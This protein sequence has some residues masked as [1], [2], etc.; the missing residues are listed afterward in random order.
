MRG[1]ATSDYCHWNKGPLCPD[2]NSY[3]AENE[4]EPLKSL[5]GFQHIGLLQTASIDYKMVQ[6]VTNNKK[7]F[8]F[9]FFF[10]TETKFV[11]ISNCNF[12]SLFFF[13][14]FLSG[15]NTDTL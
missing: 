6:Y 12:A 13:S 3:Q 1:K 11:P 7:L 9:V 2:N 8:F 4:S 5:T 15:K 14:F 10:L